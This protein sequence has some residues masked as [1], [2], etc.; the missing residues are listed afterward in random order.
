MKDMATMDLKKT[1][2]DCVETKE[3][4]DSIKDEGVRYYFEKIV[5]DS[6]R[7]L[8]YKERGEIVSSQTSATKVGNKII[9]LGDFEFKNGKSS[10]T[11]YYNN[12]L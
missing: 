6:E 4:V 8:L 12:L 1:I 7:F 3:I 2:I 11:I 5:H 10:T 9:L